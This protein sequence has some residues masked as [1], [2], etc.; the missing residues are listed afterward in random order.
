MSECAWVDTDA[1]LVT[2]FDTQLGQNS[3][4]DTLQ[5][6]YVASMIGMDA[7]DWDTWATE[8]KLPAIIIQGRFTKPL[9][10]SH[11]TILS[12]PTHIAKE[13]Q[14]IIGAVVDGDR[15]TAE[16]SAKILI[17][18]IEKIVLTVKTVNVIDTSGE[19]VQRIRLDGPT[20]IH[21]FRKADTNTN[22]WYVVGAVGMVARTST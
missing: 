17:K 11:G 13:Y 4:Y 22:Q 3:D 6:N 16:Q 1:A 19:Q 10:G 8:G 14:Y 12:T 9:E 18:R 2:L 5:V 21:P 7:T 15:A 20:G